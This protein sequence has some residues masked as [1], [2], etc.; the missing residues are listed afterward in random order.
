MRIGLACG[1]AT[2][3]TRSITATATPQL[4]HRALTD[5]GHRADTVLLERSDGARQ[6]SG[7]GAGGNVAAV[8]RPIR[9]DV[10]P[11]PVA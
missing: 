6:A 10:R 3:L 9:V 7:L 11:G 1:Q 5:G 4:L 8:P 2:A